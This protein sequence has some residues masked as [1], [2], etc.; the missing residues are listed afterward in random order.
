MRLKLGFLLLLTACSSL[1]EKGLTTLH[2]EEVYAL[3]HLP[4]A[5]VA[6]KTPWEKRDYSFL[7]NMGEWGTITYILYPDEEKNDGSIQRAKLMWKEYVSNDFFPS[8]KQYV[9]SVLNRLATQFAPNHQKRVVGFASTVSPYTFYTDYLKVKH[10]T[11]YYKNTPEPYFLH[12]VWFIN[13]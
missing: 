6:S 13:Q 7:C 8:N 10:E 12:K 4:C 2:K 3:E 11:E 1:P 9:E 5:S